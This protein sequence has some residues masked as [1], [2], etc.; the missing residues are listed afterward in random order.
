MNNRIKRAFDQIRAEETLKNSTKD[1]L[2]QEMQHCSKHTAFS[3]RYVL[4]AAACF[5]FVLLGLGGC[6]MYFTPVSVISID[7][8][9]SVEWGINRF[10]KIVS[11]KN[12]NEDGK[13]LSDSLNVAYKDYSEA[14]SLLVENPVVENYLSRDE[15]LSVTI[16]GK[17][18]SR[19]NEM[20]ET[21]RS[22]ISEIKN[23]HCSSA[24]YS[25]LE[26]AHETGL[27]CGKYKAYLILKSLD[28]NITPQDIQQMTMKEIK[29]RI[30]TLSG[31]NSGETAPSV[32]PETSSH[33][34][35]HGFG[36]NSTGKQGCE[37]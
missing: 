13:E 6:Y 28:P 12:Y 36:K 26:A 4:C 25:Q 35:W 24:D 3:Y 7:I 19:K 8:N 11:V 22:C 9:P 15:Y 31:E 14:L 2:R 20:L 18:S 17:N 1:Y 16:V 23:A 10:D 37:N 34:Q 21:V 32:F 29:N 5:F 33:G 30:D 27:S